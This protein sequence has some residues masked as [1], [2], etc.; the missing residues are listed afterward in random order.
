[1]RFAEPPT[2]ARRSS[3][4]LARARPMIGLA[5][6]V[7]VGKIDSAHAIIADRNSA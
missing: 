4:D 6:A 5:G 7:A 3:I 1:M 2:R